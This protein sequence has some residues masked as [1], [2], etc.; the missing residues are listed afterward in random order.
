[1]GRP[2]ARARVLCGA[3]A[4]VA[5]LARL[6]DSPVYPSYAVRPDRED[7]MGDDTREI[8]E[9]ANSLAQHAMAQASINGSLLEDL[10]RT[11]LSNGTI[12]QHELEIIFKNTESKFTDS[13]ILGTDVSGSAAHRNMLEILRRIAAGHGVRL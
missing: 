3:C 8:A 11:L 9:V 4:G 5:A 10:F 1:M 13:E 7:V 12:N 2:R 6:L